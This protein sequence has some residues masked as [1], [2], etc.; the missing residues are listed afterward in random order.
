MYV[1]LYVIYVCTSNAISIS[2]A[3]GTG[4]KLKEYDGAEEHDFIR[5]TEQVPSNEDEL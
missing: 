3:E 1:C 5:V 4:A 2:A